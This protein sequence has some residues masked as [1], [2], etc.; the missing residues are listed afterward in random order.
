MCVTPKRRASTP[1]DRIAAN[2]TRDSQEMET[3]VMVR[4]FRI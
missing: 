3:N 2:V 4:Y 1:K